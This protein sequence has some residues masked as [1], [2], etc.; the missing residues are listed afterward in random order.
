MFGFYGEKK[1]SPMNF[2][3]CFALFCYDL[4]GTLTTVPCFS[5]DNMLNSYTDSANLGNRA[6]F[7]TIFLPFYWL[8]G[9]QRLENFL[10]NLCFYNLFAKHEFTCLLKFDVFMGHNCKA[11]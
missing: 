11:F 10:S 6:S 7:E 3:F 1:T 9:S 8:L 2:L 4:N 5:G